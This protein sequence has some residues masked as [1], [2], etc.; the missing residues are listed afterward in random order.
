MPAP[1]MVISP[2]KQT[3]KDV[4]EILVFILYLISIHRTPSDGDILFGFEGF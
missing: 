3:K 4:K 1:C 2:S